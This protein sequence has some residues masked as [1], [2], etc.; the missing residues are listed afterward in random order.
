M[1]YRY[2]PPVYAEKL[3][4]KNFGNIGHLTGS[5]MIDTEDKLLSLEEQEKYTVKKKE[6]LV[7]SLLLRKK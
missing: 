6:T 4:P 3:I 7:M 2:L 5:K 1:E